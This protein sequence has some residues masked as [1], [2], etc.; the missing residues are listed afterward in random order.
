MITL[1]WVV[2]AMVLTVIVA[3][4][5]LFFAPSM[6][7]AWLIMILIA[8]GNMGDAYFVTHRL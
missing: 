5:G 3:V 1:Q 7:P 6:L 2:S 8:L 4:A